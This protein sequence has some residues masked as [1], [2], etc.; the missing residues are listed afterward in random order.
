[1]VSIHCIATFHSISWGGIIIISTLFSSCSFD[2]LLQYYKRLETDDYPKLL[3]C[4]DL[5]ISL[6]TSTSGIDLPIKIIDMF[7]CQVPVCAIRYSCI[8]EVMRHG[9][10]GMVFNTSD[11]LAGQM[12][13]LLDSSLI[14]ESMRNNI[15]SMTR[16]EEEW[17]TVAKGMICQLCE[18]GRI[19]RQTNCKLRRFIFYPVVVALS[20]L[21]LGLCY[22]WRHT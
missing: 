13:D 21:C 6:H 8:T 12:L 11:E 14:L 10:N 3:G 17:N 1:V 22:G 15:S 4:A 5:G 2:R 7:G 19:Q 20:A 18:V 9:W 16:W